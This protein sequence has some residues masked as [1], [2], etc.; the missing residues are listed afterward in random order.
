MQAVSLSGVGLWSTQFKTALFAF[1]PSVSTGDIYILRYSS[2]PL[3]FLAIR[4]FKNW[5]CRHMQ[6]V[7]LS[8]VFRSIISLVSIDAALEKQ[9]KKEKHSDRTDSLH[10]ACG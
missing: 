1:E 5:R 3:V 8:G 6:A 2:L 7:S 10:L 9:D 4:Q